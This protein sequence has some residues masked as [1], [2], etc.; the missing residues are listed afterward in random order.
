MRFPRTTITATYE[1]HSYD[2]EKRAALE[3]WERDCVKVVLKPS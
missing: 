1:R 3:R 2:L